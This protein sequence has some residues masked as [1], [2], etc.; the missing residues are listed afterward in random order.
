MKEDQKRL[1]IALPKPLIHRLKLEATRTEVPIYQ[2]VASV[3]DAAL[4]RKIDVVTK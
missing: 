1:M 2:L 4:P 3:L